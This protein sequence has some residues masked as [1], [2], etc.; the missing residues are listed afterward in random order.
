M[1]FDTPVVLCIFNR[2]SVTR[3]VVTAIRQARPKTLL[4]IGDG[5]R[6]NR[7]GEH[8]LVAKTRA[9]LDDV[10]WPCDVQTNYS[11]INLGC[12]SRVASGLAWVFDKYSEAI[13]LEDDCLP[14]AS[15]FPWCRDM[16]ARYR[17]DDRVFSVAGTNFQA[18]RSRCLNGYYFSKYF[19]C[20]GWASWRRVWQTVDLD[21]RHWPEFIAQG[22]LDEIADSPAEHRYWDRIL[23]DQYRGETDSWAY[24]WLASAW[25]TRSLSILPDVNLVSNIGFDEGATHT[26]GRSSPLANIPTKALRHWSEPDSIA[27]NVMADAFTFNHVFAEPSQLHRWKR[28]IVRRWAQWSDRKAA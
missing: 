25:M 21:M 2:P 28:S 14:D 27:R 16:L 19:H 5:A 6:P 10:D 17:D 18:G 4:V 15:F 9:V 1:A 22:G 12:R 8:E 20:W 3:K 11:S 23:G 26:K 7:P 13:V 24:S